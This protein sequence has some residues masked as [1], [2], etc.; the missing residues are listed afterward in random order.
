[1]S[2]VSSQRRRLLV[3]AALTPA[4]FVGSLYLH[5]EWLASVGCLIAFAGL[6]ASVLLYLDYRR[7]STVPRIANP[8]IGF[9]NLQGP[10]GTA[11]VDADRA[12]LAPLFKM[13]HL[14]TDVPPQCEVLFL[15]CTLDAEGR[16]VG[17]AST[18]GDLIQKA[19]AYVA[20]VASENKPECYTKAIP[21]RR[22]WRANIVLVIDRKA[23][24]FAM[25]FRRLFEAMFNGRSMVMAWVKLAPQNPRRYDPDAPA[26]IMVAQA[27]H[28]RFGG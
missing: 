26:T 10:K 13:S 25:F 17:S 9:L 15:Y 24:K 20:V 4:I 22:D 27:G 14:S 1:M 23:E 18:I 5:P 12:V 19:G 3:T 16:I 2:G 21:R 6:V 8:A 7:G 28:V 11:L